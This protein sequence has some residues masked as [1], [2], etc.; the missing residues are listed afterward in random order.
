M[1]FSKGN[2]CLDDLKQQNRKNNQQIS[3]QVEF[4]YKMGPMKVDV[5][6]AKQKQAEK[7]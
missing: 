6:A 3:D 7:E 4:S 5:E 2:F 1:E